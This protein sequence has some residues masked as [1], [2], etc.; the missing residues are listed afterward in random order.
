MPAV[1]FISC[2]TWY[3]VLVRKT[4][5]LR[6]QQRL[7]PRRRARKRSSAL[8]RKLRP[9]RQHRPKRRPKKRL[10]SFSSNRRLLP[11][12]RHLLAVTVHLAQQMGTQTRSLWWK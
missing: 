12:H 5:E 9:E 3:Y 10:K 8:A 11:S 1:T 6:R 4:Y 2:I 7:Q